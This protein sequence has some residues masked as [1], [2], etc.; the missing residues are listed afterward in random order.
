MT[1]YE[2]EKITKKEV[3]LS[4]IAMIAGGCLAVIGC[5]QCYRIGKIKGRNQT[6]TSIVDMSASKGLIMVNPD[7]GRY[8]F[9][10]EK[11]VSK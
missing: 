7:R 4:S 1:K 8:L 10:A 5:V 11:L 9:T 2:S 6:L 3:I